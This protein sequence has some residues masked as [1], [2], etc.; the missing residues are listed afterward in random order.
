MDSVRAKNIIIIILIAA[1]SAV[2]IGGAVYV[3]VSTNVRN[4]NREYFFD[5]APVD[6]SKQENFAYRAL[7]KEAVMN[8]F[9]PLADN[10]GGLTEQ[11]EIFAERLLNAMSVSRISGET[12]GQMANSIK[13]HKITDVLGGVDLGDLSEE[14]LKNIMKVSAL[15]VIGN[16]F[17]AFFLETGLTGEETGTVIYNYLDIYASAEYRV[18]LYTIGKEDFV[19]FIAIFTYFLSS[20]S[21]IKTGTT[22]IDE[23]AL[24]G[25]C[26]ELGANFLR[27]GKDV[28]VLEKVF[29][30][31]FHFEDKEYGA[32]ASVFSQSLSKKMGSLFPLIG[33]I[34]TECLANDI[35]NAL[36]YAENGDT[37]SLILSQSGFARSIK[38]GVDRFLVEYGADF[39]AENYEEFQERINLIVKDLYS[40]RMTILGLSEEALQDEEFL[41]T[42]QESRENFAKFF[43]AVEVLKD[44]DG[45]L[46]LTDEEKI[47]LTA[48]ARDM[49]AIEKDGGDIVGCIVYLWVAQILYDTEML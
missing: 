48:V 31:R 36:D 35:K 1:I 16:F 33:Y 7:F 34:L 12:L 21:E 23:H 6:Y 39:G 41:Q 47:S 42:L 45:N 32:S 9:A 11:S 26:Y 8:Y 37:D 14:D 29:N 30:L 15:D 3:A 49:W 10:I 25:A 4:E 44:F 38:R 40:L 22:D 43:S 24:K 27:V 20:V 13:K 18:A 17:D 2:I 46:N 19:S 5:S 28:E